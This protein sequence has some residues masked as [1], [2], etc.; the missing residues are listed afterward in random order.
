[1]YEEPVSL[2]K[3]EVREPVI[4][5][6]II[7]AIAT[8]ASRMSE[9]ATKVG[10]ST[11]T[12]TAYIKNLI[13]LGIIKR[14][15]PYGEK[16]SK[17]TIYSIEDNMFYLYRLD[18]GGEMIPEREVRRKLILWGSRI[19]IRQYLQSVNGKMILF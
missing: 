19:V 17:K 6:A 15:T 10:E 16:T 8:G 12:C 3:Q 4:Y 11:T 18:V 14:E 5:N 2:L 13:N 1:M 7:T 9:I